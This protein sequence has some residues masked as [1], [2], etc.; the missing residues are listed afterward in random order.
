MA[1]IKTSSHIDQTLDGMLSTFSGSVSYIAESVMGNEYSGDSGILGLLDQ[2]A[3]LRAQF[4]ANGD[5]PVT[6]TT[7]ENDS[8]K[9]VVKFEG[10]KNGSSITTSLTDG[11][12]DISVDQKTDKVTFNYVNAAK[13]DFTI[14][15]ISGNWAG[16]SKRDTARDWYSD[17]WS[18]SASITLSSRTDS[19][20]DRIDPIDTIRVYDF[21]EKENIKGSMGSN[22]VNDFNPYLEE[23]WSQS[24]SRSFKGDFEFNPE[25]EAGFQGGTVSALSYEKAA[26]GQYITPDSFDES[27]RSY[28]R[29][30][31]FKLTSSGLDIVN[32]AEGYV[33][34]TTETTAK[35]AYS[36]SYLEKSKNS[37]SGIADVAGGTDSLDADLDQDDFTAISDYYNGKTDIQALKEKLL[38]G[39]DSITITGTGSAAGG[40]AE[41]WGGKD[42]I[43]GGGGS[44]IIWGG[45]GDD[46]INGKAG[47]DSLYGDAGNDKL[48]GDLGMDLL[49]G[50]AGSDTLQGGDGF[51]VL[52]GDGTDSSTGADGNDSLD[53]GNGNDKLY[54]GSG[55]DTLIGGVGNDLLEG[56]SGDDSLNGGVGN[57]VLKGGGGK[58]ILTGG[59]GK[60]IFNAGDDYHWTT[61]ADQIDSITDFS[62]ADDVLTFGSNYGDWLLADSAK[63]IV[64]AS[65]GSTYEDLLQL[66]QDKFASAETE[67]SIV[68]GK[69]GKDTFVFYE[70]AGDGI[71]DPETQTYSDDHT[72]DAAIK[73]V[74]VSVT[75]ESDIKVFDI[76]AAF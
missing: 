72:I 57:D 21:S 76:G 24:T 56:G 44:D 60:D 65:T 74:G 40:S 20:Y 27:S 45:D 34:L 28:S 22:E 37:L 33:S 25:S 36:Y 17:E 35:V 26:S 59:T 52:Y 42:T 46:I 8:G 51:D 13:D 30:I 66:A 69:L 14:K 53:G 18:G 31:K 6:K 71:F 19:G 11:S 9:T 54:G 38:D 1:T 61:V 63:T 68:L 58:D 29:D 64:S 39:N 48:Y 15:S 10:L 70:H 75:K 3:V 16:S 32:D 7:D 23:K 67:L 50:G 2:E 49:V 12:R 73:L 62:K 55:K 47:R 5:K 43:T 4:M 41:G